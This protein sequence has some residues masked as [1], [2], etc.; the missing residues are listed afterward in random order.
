MYMKSTIISEGGRPASTSLVSPYGGPVITGKPGIMLAPSRFG[1]SRSPLPALCR[2]ATSCAWR[3]RLR[4]IPDGRFRCSLGRAEVRSGGHPW[5]TLAAQ[6]VARRNRS[7]VL[8]R[9][10]RPKWP[11]RRSKRP[12]GIERGRAP[13]VTYSAVWGTCVP[14]V[15]QV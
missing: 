4:K 9:P 2:Q 10:W 12:N 3:S 5:A 1:F 15:V 14:K 13:N 8:G 11:K 7:G 6:T